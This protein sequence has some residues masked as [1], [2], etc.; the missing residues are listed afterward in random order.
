MPV[1]DVIEPENRRP[2]E[3]S[4]LLNVPASARPGDRHR[5]AEPVDE[6]A[7]EDDEDIEF[8]TTLAQQAARDAQ[9]LR[10]VPS[11]K[12]RRFEVK[13]DETL[14]AFKDTYVERP[15]ARILNNMRIDAVEMDDLLEQLSTTAA[16]LRQR[17]AA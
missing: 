3:R 5:W 16:A 9:P 14:D 11:P 17:K 12:A 4:A 13:A 10:A 2:H 7:D 15:R 6:S 1:K 8:L